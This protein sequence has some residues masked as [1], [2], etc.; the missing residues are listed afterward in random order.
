MMAESFRSAFA[1]LGHTAEVFFVHF[2]H[3]HSLYLMKLA[4]RFSLDR[5]MLRWWQAYKNFSARTYEEKIRSWNP[6]LVLMIGF[7]GMDSASIRR[8]VQETKTAVAYYVI[9]DP[10][11]TGRSDA[12][13]LDHLVACSHLFFQCPKSIPAMR[14]ISEAHCEELVVPADPLI[15]KSIANVEQDIDILMVGHFASTSISTTTKLYLL[16]YLCGQGLRVSIAGSGAGRA[17]KNPLFPDLFRARILFDRSISGEELNMLH[18]RAKI[19]LATGHLRDKGAPHPRVIEAALSGAFA[20]ADNQP[21]IGTMFSNSV[22]TC[23]TAED[24]FEGSKYYLAHPQRRESMARTAQEVASKKY[25]HK[26]AAEQ[27]VQSVFLRQTT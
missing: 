7:N 2:P 3:H 24:F 16:N 15:F 19:V 22:P 11:V 17:I 9:A 21:D 14:L 18:N 26:Y 1:F 25:T 4:K 12:L 5:P 13:Y 6:D 20:L 8:V 10:L 27:I 23:V